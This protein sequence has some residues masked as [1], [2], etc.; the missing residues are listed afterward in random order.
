MCCCIPLP[1][2]VATQKAQILHSQAIQVLG[3]CYNIR[4]NLANPHV[5]TL[6][7]YA[8]LHCAWTLVD[9]LRQFGCPIDEQDG[10]FSIIS[11]PSHVISGQMWTPLHVAC[12]NANYETAVN[13]LMRGASV[14]VRDSVGST[15][16]HLACFSGIL[17][18]TTAAPANATQAM[19]TLLGFYYKP[20]LI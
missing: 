5:R 4:N 1:Q 10:I 9:L 20:G 2:A 18:F 15:P 13:L 14:R 7:H 6:M 19:L 11:L 8:V 16:L 17:L 12:S 3:L